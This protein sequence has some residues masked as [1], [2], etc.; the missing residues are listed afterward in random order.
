M[1]LIE[2]LP[3]PSPGCNSRSPLG[4][5]CGSASVFGPAY[6][7]TVKQL[8]ESLMARFDEDGDA[9]L[10]LA[11]A[12]CLL[13]A[14]IGLTSR[15]KVTAA[16]LDRE[17]FSAICSDPQKGLALSELCELLDLAD[18]ALG[19]CPSAAKPA[20]AA[21]AAE[22][23]D[24]PMDFLP[25]QLG[26][27]ECCGD[28]DHLGDKI[29]RRR[30]K[31]ALRAEP[32]RHG[33]AADALQ[34]MQLLRAVRSGD[35]E[36]LQTLLSCSVLWDDVNPRVLDEGLQQA[37]CLSTAR[38]PLLYSAAFAGHIG[39]LRLLVQLL[40][41]QHKLDE[42][43]SEEVEGW[44]L[45]M[46]VLLGQSSPP[47]D[48]FLLQDFLNLLGEATLRRWSESSGQLVLP[49]LHFKAGIRPLELV[50]RQPDW[51]RAVMLLVRSGGG[52][53]HKE[54]ASRQLLL[55]VLLA[56]TGSTSAF[57]EACRDGGDSITPGSEAF[58]GLFLGSLQLGI[59]PAD[60]LVAL[61][62]LVAHGLKP[63]AQLSAGGGL[64]PLH[65][66]ARHDSVWMVRG[67]LALGADPKLLDGRK[68]TALEIARKANSP[69]C[70]AALQTAAKQGWRP[71]AWEDIVEAAA[72]Q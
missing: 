23:P 63:N 1:T 25:G 4:D 38:V 40:R 58:A 33:R 6:D 14:S 60:S 5:D 53:P 28:F 64:H 12:R 44:T 21:L 57:L 20:V 72:E 41:S 8:A 61:D 70:V 42:A 26:V 36:S 54:G 65:A 31:T 27:D 62:A 17:T 24:M 50:L 37:L 66:A 35:E 18:G 49:M 16:A 34:R 52:Y 11:E 2:V 51:P 3:T 69:G 15:S 47:K 45:P 19:G 30:V 71:A 10:S 13:K 43:L 59:T 55:G 67:L 46:A 9:H 22:S 48:R 68:R 32:P 56:G 39:V 7:K 29:A